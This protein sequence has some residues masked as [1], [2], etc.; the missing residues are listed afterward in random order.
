MYQHSARAPSPNTEYII[1]RSRRQCRM[2]K[3]GLGGLF[4]S[5]VPPVGYTSRSF[6][7][8]DTFDTE[9]SQRYAYDNPHT[10]ID[11]PATH[12]ALFIG[13]LCTIRADGVSHQYDMTYVCCW[14]PGSHHGAHS[15]REMWVVESPVLVTKPSRFTGRWE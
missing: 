11:R 5:A 1:S 12:S 3:T 13:R 14:L 9:L 8:G 10:I 2:S 6:G 4:V 15:V 7:Y